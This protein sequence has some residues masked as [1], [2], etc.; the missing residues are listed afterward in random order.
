MKNL[1][2]K[3]KSKG[4]LSEDKSQSTANSKPK[5]KKK[6]NRKA[7]WS[8]K[9]LDDFVDIIC[10]NENHKQKKNKLIFTDA[11]PNTKNSEIYSDVIEELNMRTKYT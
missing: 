5:K 8:T 6:P 11:K 7:T 1:I 2:E 10:E 4:K 9:I 3:Q